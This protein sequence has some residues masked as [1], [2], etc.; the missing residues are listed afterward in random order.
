MPFHRPIFIT[1]AC[2]YPLHPCD[3]YM[4]LA[5]VR[6]MHALPPGTPI[7]LVPHWVPHATGAWW[8][9]RR[10][11]RWDASR[12]ARMQRERRTNCHQYIPVQLRKLGGRF[13]T[14]QAQTRFAKRHAPEGLV[15]CPW[16]LHYG[17]REELTTSRSYRAK[18]LCA[19]CY[20]L[21]HVNEKRRKA[22]YWRKHKDA[23]RQ[24][25]AKF[26][27]EKEATR[28]ELTA[29]RNLKAAVAQ[30]IVEMRAPDPVSAFAGDTA[31]PPMGTAS[32]PSRRA[33]GYTYA[34]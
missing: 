14:P 34:H 30:E 3:N 12:R 17:P 28:R 26:V 21:S 19:A 25:L 5:A 2:T 13:M 10:C 15:W 6:K 16:G 32:S 23:M 31:Y 4:G 22:R 27:Q 20:V 24:E 29:L 1:M 8:W 9:C 11:T 18:G 33:K 7:V